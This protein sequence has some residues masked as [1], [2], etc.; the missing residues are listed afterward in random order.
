MSIRPDQW[1]ATRS[2]PPTHILQTVHGQSPQFAWEGITHTKEQLRSF[3]DRYMATQVSHEDLQEEGWVPMI[4]PFEMEQ[5]RYKATYPWMNGIRKGEIS[6]ANSQNAEMFRTG[7]GPKL[8]EDDKFLYHNNQLDIK[9]YTWEDELYHVPERVISYGNSSYGY[10]VRLSEEFK[11]FTNLNSAVIDPKRFDEKCLIDAELKTDPN[12]DKY[13]ILPPNSYLLGRT[14]E[15][16]HIPRNVTVVA[17]GKSTYAR[18][19]AIVNVTPIEAEF[20]GNVVIEIS[21]STNL[22]LKI[23]A[24][25]GISQFLFFESDQECKTSYAD[26]DGK[27]MHQTGVVLPR[28]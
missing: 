18:A 6:I 20:Q 9:A 27:Y 25:E 16:F 11:L 3:T 13:V 21:N 12:G 23:Y 8:T 14:I 2:T 24:N 26:R 5:V 15:Y 28:I 10:D 1:I 19:G 17:V 22:P 7:L 4:E